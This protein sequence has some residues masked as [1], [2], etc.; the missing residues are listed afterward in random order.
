MEVL[1]SCRVPCRRSRRVEHS[2]CVPV[3]SIRILQKAAGFMGVTT[4]VCRLQAGVMGSKRQER[5]SDEPLVQHCC[6][7]DLCLDMLADD[8]ARCCW[9]DASNTQL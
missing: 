2:R 8:E 1:R 3:Y 7:A 9:S 5:L 6:A 4:Q